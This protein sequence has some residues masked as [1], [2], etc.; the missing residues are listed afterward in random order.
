MSN[1]TEA[2]QAAPL[3][4]PRGKRGLMALV[5]QEIITFGLKSTLTER[6][7]RVALS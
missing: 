5:N 2:A 3:V 1:A 7:T 6:V 4:D